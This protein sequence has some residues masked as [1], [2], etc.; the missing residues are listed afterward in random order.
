[1]TIATCPRWAVCLLLSAPSI[2]SAGHSG[3]P[4]A[5]DE[6]PPQPHERP[7]EPPAPARPLRTSPVAEARL[8]TRDG[9]VSVQVNT[10]S[11]GLNIV[12]DAGNETSMAVDPGRPNRI[13]IGWR[14]FDSI[15]STFREAG[16]AW[17]RD[18]GHTWTNGGV[19]A[20]GEFRTDPVLDFDR[21]GNVYYHSLFGAD[22]RNC[23]VF[24]SVDGGRTWGPPVRAGGGDK[25]WL[26][27]DRSGGIGDGNVYTMWRADFSCCGLNQFN[28][29]IDGG[30]TFSPP[31]QV[32]NRP[33]M[34]TLAIGPDGA[35]FIAGVNINNRAQFFVVRSDSARDA[36]L[37][38]LFEQ[39]VQVPMNGVLSFNVGTGPNPGGLL[40]QPWIAV[41][42]SAGPT[43]G[44]VYLLSSVDPTGADPQDV[45][46]VRST[47]GGLTWSQP[48][49]VNDTTAGNAWQWF[50]T[51]GLAP[52]GRL[53]AVWCD[54]TNSGQV[55]LSEIRFSSSVDAGA[56]W[57]PSVPITPV[58]NSHV[59]WPNQNKIGDYFQLAS[60]DVGAS[61]A[62]TATFNGEQDVYFLRIGDYDCNG[63][64]V[65][66]QIDVLAR[67]SLDLNADMIP[68][69]C[70][71]LADL[72]GDLQVDVEDLSLILSAFGTSSGDPA[73]DARLDPNQD[74][75]IGLADL[76]IVLSG[77][78]LP[79]P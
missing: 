46:F 59:G 15:A 47:D 73:Y 62:F 23:D 64:G 70:Q 42:R 76:A 11:D 17:S 36:A 41:D 71:C 39:T 72:S 54:T 65:S 52:N 31:V 32:P 50:G 69:E 56:T 53:D 25:N 37:P 34:V 20:E 6:F 27:V 78:G 55:N 60:D 24:K 75:Q 10:T 68:D 48:V 1:M 22:L 33:A 61:L 45:H 30:A 18:G 12:G 77:F 14:Q 13:A 9:F 79:C 21:N 44:N 7:G 4:A 8:R 40:G 5:P 35:V 57:S 58:F 74:G 63:N 2:C 29:S 51:L 49:R 16:F 26:V 28:R 66:D 43:H 19:L 38:L 3:A 67:R